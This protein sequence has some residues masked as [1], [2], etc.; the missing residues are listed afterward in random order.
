MTVENEGAR[1]WLFGCEGAAGVSRVTGDERV[2]VM[3]RVIVPF[4][5][6]ECVF[7]NCGRWWKFMCLVARAKYLYSGIMTH[8]LTGIQPTFLH[9]YQFVVIARALFPKWPLF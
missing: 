6:C 5:N 2:L 7:R 3:A 8:N 1:G 9:V 4:C